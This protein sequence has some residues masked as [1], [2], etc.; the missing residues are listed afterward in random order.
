[1]KK[2][3]FILLCLPIIGFGQSKKKLKNY[4]SSLKNDSISMS[5]I[6]NDLENKNVSQQILI[7][8]SKKINALNN[9]SII[10]LNNLIDSL[11]INSI[12]KDSIIFL[13]NLIDSLKINSK[14][15]NFIESFYE[16]FELVNDDESPKYV[17]FGKKIDNIKLNFSGFCYNLSERRINN[18]TGNNHDKY[19][20][21]LLKI[22]KIN[23][24]IQEAMGLELSV[25]E[26]STD[27][28]YTG[29]ELGSFY[30]K[31]ELI[32]CDYNG[33]LTVYRWNDI[34]LYR[35]EVSEYDGLEN[36]SKQDFYNFIGIIG[37]AYIEII[38]D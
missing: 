13:N 23:Y 30:N 32:I 3:L 9:D 35:M 38:S 11:R 37:D 14:T 2:L 36:F 26:V 16:A 18:L 24:D 33:H 34:D 1:M 28:L 22:N 27:V 17:F 19:Y 12:N 7:E 15:R 20:I 6:I 5:L 25:I 21:E 8:D 4:I 31:E 10:L 29:Y